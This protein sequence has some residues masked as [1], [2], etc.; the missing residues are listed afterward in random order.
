MGK[1][2]KLLIKR[3]QKDLAYT[4]SPIFKKHYPDRDQEKEIEELRK[5]IVDRLKREKM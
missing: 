4:Q 1:I 3:L 5:E 2:N